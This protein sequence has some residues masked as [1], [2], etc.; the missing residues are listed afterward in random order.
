MLHDLAEIEASVHWL[1]GEGR[2]ATLC[3]HGDKPAAVANADR[4][5]SILSH[6]GIAITSFLD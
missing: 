1:V 3:V 6:R 5:R 4:I 2:V